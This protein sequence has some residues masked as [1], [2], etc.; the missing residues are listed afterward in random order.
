MDIVQDALNC[1]TC[2]YGSTIHQA[3]TTR[4]RQ[5]GTIFLR[6]GY[7]ANTWPRR[8]CS[9]AAVGLYW[10]SALISTAAAKA[11]AEPLKSEDGDCHWRLR[12][13]RLRSNV[14]L[15]SDNQLQFPAV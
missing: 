14:H 9:W 13:G 11:T 8:F 15:A 2:M 4:Q 7:K 5:P 6:L 3:R 10:W 12:S 1:S